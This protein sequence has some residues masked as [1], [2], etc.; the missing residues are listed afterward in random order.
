MICI[1]QQE[2][3]YKKERRCKMYLRSF[4]KC[5]QGKRGSV[6]FVYNKLSHRAW[7]RLLKFYT[8]NVKI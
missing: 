1:D 3:F 7:Q 8:D 5:C 2:V 4:Y 6:C